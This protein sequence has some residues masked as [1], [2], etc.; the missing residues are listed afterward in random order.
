[1]TFRSNR[2]PPGDGGGDAGTL[3]RAAVRRCYDG[4]CRCGQPERYALEAAVIVYRWHHPETPVSLAENIV[5]QW[6]G[7]VVRH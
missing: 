3:S 6:V 4:L 5:A 1:M 7:S 2:Q